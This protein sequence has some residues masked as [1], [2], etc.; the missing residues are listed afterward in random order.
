MTQANVNVAPVPE[1][2]YMLFLFGTSGATAEGES[3]A[4]TA[5]GREGWCVAGVVHHGEGVL[6]ARQTAIRL[7]PV[8][9]PDIIGMNNARLTLARGNGRDS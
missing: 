9:E 2:E 4:L 3:A 7:I 5:L 6:L 8:K 1:Y